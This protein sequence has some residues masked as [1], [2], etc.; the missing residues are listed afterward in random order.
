MNRILKLVFF[1]AVIFAA[2]AYTCNASKVP[3]SR[4]PKPKTQKYTTLSQDNDSMAV[5]NNDSQTSQASTFL[6]IQQTLDVEYRHTLKANLV[7]ISS[8]TSK[9]T[10]NSYITQMPLMRGFPPCH[11]YIYTLRQIII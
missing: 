11:Y 8:D 3:C 7:F 2:N 5:M 1:L 6:R 10:K 9:E 4:M